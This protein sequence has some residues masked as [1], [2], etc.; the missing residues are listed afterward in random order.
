MQFALNCV[1]LPDDFTH[2]IIDRFISTG[3]SFNVVSVQMKLPWE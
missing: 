1:L 2:I 3:A